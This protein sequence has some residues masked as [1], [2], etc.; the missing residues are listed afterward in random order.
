MLGRKT[1][2]PKLFDAFSLEERVPWIV[3]CAA[4]PPASTATLVNLASILSPVQAVPA[5]LALRHH[6]RAAA[7]QRSP[8]APGLPLVPELR[9]RRDAARSLGALE[10][11]R[12]VRRDGLSGVLHRDRAAV[13]AGGAH[14]GR[15]ALSGQHA[16]GGTCQPRC[17]GG[18]RSGLVA[19]LA[20]VDEHRA[21]LWQENPTEPEETSPPP[22]TPTDP[23]NAP[24]GAQLA[25]PLDLPPA[26]VARLVHCAPAS[27]TPGPP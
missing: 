24:L 18:A 23:P 5:R 8:A 2:A 4:W 19:Q 6:Q 13:R 26:L 25:S 7:G 17:A 10:G 20:D 9:P 21:P 16:G 14:P 1:F 11:A 3:C 15:P 22:P 12:P 27:R